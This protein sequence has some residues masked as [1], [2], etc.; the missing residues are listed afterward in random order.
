MARHAIG[1]LLLLSIAGSTWGLA[2]QASETVAN[3]SASI[4]HRINSANER[5]EMV[6]NTS[7][8]LTLE[9]K[10]PQAQ[11]NNPDV[12]DLT[13]LSPTEI[14]LAAKKAGVT[15]VN[16]WD[17]N[18]NIFTVDV[19]VYGDTRE[20]EM[21]LSEQFPNASLKV[22][23]YADSVLVSGFVDQPHDVTSIVQIAQTFYPNK[24][25]T[26][27][28]VGGVQQVLL[29]VKVMEV[30][31]T[32]LRALGFDWTYL[33]GA[34]QITSAAA[35]LISAVTPADGDT[36]SSVTGSGNFRFN[37]ING[38]TTFFGVLEAMRRDNMAKLL[39]EP[40]LVTVS[41]RPAS[42]QSGGE[43]PVVTG[44]G[45]GVPSNTVYKPYGTQ[46]DFVPIVLGNG[47][48][49]LEIRPEVSEIDGARSVDG[50]PAFRNRRVDTGVEMEAGQTLAIAGLIQTRIE[51]E[52]RGIPWVS[53]LPYVGA[54]F[55]R[56]EEERNEVELLILV[57]PE[58]VAGM[59]AD[60][61][62]ECGP[63][64]QTASPNDWELYLRGYVEVPNCCPACQG[65]GCA[66][67]ADA[68]PGD[69]KLPP[70]IDGGEG[71]VIEMK[72][73][74]TPDSGPVPAPEAVPPASPAPSP[75]APSAASATAPSRARS[76]GPTG[77]SVPKTLPVSAGGGPAAQLPGPIGPFGYDSAG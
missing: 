16:L 56:T 12:L 73:I 19:I 50:Q 55:R 41:G 77:S 72:E 53:E 20:L 44:G 60:Q 8:I 28:Q 22:R 3:R 11:V 30:S 49:R 40:T 27:L 10:I 70:M 52:R 34:N 14:Q 54:A 66:K 47:R 25:T 64:M 5:Q 69:G 48:I 9:R 29:H 38:P 35:G 32:K 68:V 71:R 76:G 51:E 18:N 75:V 61:V 21:I 26:R 39:A 36:P 6:V 46:V 2:V 43:V 65:K 74:P 37:V 23:G 4:I 33:S 67:C 63:G 58:L 24:V 31:R 62:P 15:Q 7:R 57:T 17:E 1:A 59:D 42:F 45:L 13:P